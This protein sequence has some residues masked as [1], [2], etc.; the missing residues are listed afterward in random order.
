MPRL[1]RGAEPIETGCDGAQT[2]PDLCEHSESR[3]DSGMGIIDISL[4]ARRREAASHMYMVGQVVRMRNDGPRTARS[5]DIFRI[6]AKLP[7]NDGLP[8]YRLRNATERFERVA[9][10]DAIEPLTR[11]RSN[12]PLS[13]AERAFEGKKGAVE[14]ADEG[15]ISLPTPIL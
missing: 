5:A 11:S 3:K 10:Q 14:G 12:S 4:R 1:C 15:V 6:T 7:P 13:P 9:T 8:Q 2:L